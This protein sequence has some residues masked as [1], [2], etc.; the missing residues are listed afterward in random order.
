[1]KTPSSNHSQ[2]VMEIYSGLVI[3]NYIG[4]FTVDISRYKG[5]KLNWKTV[6]VFENG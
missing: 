4:L 3:F 1:M 5:E 2:H 6:L